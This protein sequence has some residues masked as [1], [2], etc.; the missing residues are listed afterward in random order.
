MPGSTRVTV[1][2]GTKGVAGFEYSIMVI[3]Y[4]V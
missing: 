4:Y 3:P 2:C 1:D